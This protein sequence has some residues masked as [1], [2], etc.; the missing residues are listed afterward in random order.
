M[1]K[2]A[3][4][5]N[6][7]NNEN[8]LQRNVRDGAQLIYKSSQGLSPLCARGRYDV[9]G[10]ILG[11][12]P[13]APLT[14]RNGHQFIIKAIFAIIVCFWTYSYRGTTWQQLYF[15]ENIILF[16]KLIS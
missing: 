6:I 8:R 5:Y 15:G 2:I 7:A 16:I 1:Q 11:R 4:T 10:S 12:A 14:I 9:P 13:F 3:K